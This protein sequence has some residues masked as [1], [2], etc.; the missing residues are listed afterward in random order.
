MELVVGVSQFG[1]LP[2]TFHYLDYTQG[3]SHDVIEK[4]V[5]MLHQ[6]SAYHFM[7]QACCFKTDSVI[8]MRQC[9][10]LIIVLFF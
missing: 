1:D 5:S 10:A 7:N 6:R 8:L 4:Y 2:Q 9:P 3:C